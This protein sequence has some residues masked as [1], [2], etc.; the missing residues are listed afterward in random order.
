VREDHYPYSAKGERGYPSSPSTLCAR[1]FG[2]A[3]ARDLHGYGAVSVKTIGS[4]YVP[5]ALLAAE[6]PPAQ[7]VRKNAAAAVLFEL[8][9]EA[10]VTSLA[11]I[12][13]YVPPEV[14]AH[15]RSLM[16]FTPASEPLYVKV[17]AFCDLTF[18]VQLRLALIVN[19]G[20]TSSRDNADSMSV[21]DGAV[22]VVAGELIAS[23]TSAPTVTDA[24]L[25]VLQLPVLLLHCALAW[26]APTAV[27]STIAARSKRVAF[28][29]GSLQEVLMVPVTRRRNRSFNRLCPTA[30]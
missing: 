17:V 29:F 5:G 30:L 8:T 3:R 23:L 2:R 14:V 6:N 1:P 26:L 9:P 22:N 7:L 21:T 24:V 4:V 15:E 16:G 13:E 10:K 28:I 19:V 12:G 25:V 27:P 11:V 18:R 20:P